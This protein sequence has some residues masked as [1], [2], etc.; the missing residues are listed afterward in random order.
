MNL[1]YKTDDLKN[2]KS[3]NL[4]HHIRLR[5]NMLYSMFK[6]RVMLVSE[7]ERKD[8]RNNQSVTSEAKPYAMPVFTLVG[9]GKIFIDKHAAC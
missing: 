2:N 3:I 9:Q 1:I 8:N 7:Y 5:L 6:R 4:A